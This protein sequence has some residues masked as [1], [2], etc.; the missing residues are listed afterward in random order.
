MGAVRTGTGVVFCVAVLCLACGT[1]GIGGHPDATDTDPV[2]EEDLPGEPDGEMDPVEI[3]DEPDTEPVVDPAVEPDA[4]PDDSGLLYSVWGSSSDDV[5]VV[6]EHG[7]ILQFDG[8]EWSAMES[9]SDRDQLLYVWGSGSDDVYALPDYAL[10]FSILH[11]DGVRWNDVNIGIE[12]LRCPKAIWGVSAEDVFLATDSSLIPVPPP[13]PHISHFDGT[14]WSTMAELPSWECWSINDL[15]G[16]SGTEVIAVG[17]GATLTGTH[18]G[19]I[20]RYTAGEWTL[21]D[22]QAPDELLGVWGSAEDDVFAVGESG[23]IVHFDGHDWSGMESGTTAILSGVWGSSSTDV[24]AVG[25]TGSGPDSV[26]LR[27]D[28]IEWSDMETGLGARLNAIWGSS[29]TDIYAVGGYRIGYRDF[30]GA[31]FHFDGEAWTEVYR[32]GE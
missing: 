2:E 19:A 26:V 14:I 13:P 5:F 29:A 28:G 12:V 32:D 9:V 24:Y 18:Y 27:Y 15:W 30:E 11:F 22:Y 16:T 20:V 23:T 3:R 10:R 31:V 8:S 21:L 1:R 7:K 6:G 17:E 25:Y 4:P